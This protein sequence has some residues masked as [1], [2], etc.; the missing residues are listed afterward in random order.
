MFDHR[1]AQYMSVTFTTNNCKTKYYIVY[2]LTCNAGSRLI[3]QN[4]TYI[5]HFTVSLCYS[6]LKLFVVNS[7]SLF[8]VY[9]IPFI[10]Y[11]NLP[12]R[13]ISTHQF[14]F[15]SPTI[16]QNILLTYGR[17][18]FLDA[19]T[20]QTHINHRHFPYIIKDRDVFYYF[21]NSKLQ[22]HTTQKLSNFCKKWKFKTYI[23]LEK[24]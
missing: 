17:G 10:Y 15:W 12:V 16:D 18:N 4:Q 2:T 6:V 19:Q 21:L 8:T 1:H 11:Y 24:Y 9:Y 22:E 23:N 20:R 3:F 14:W 13:V 5:S 7:F